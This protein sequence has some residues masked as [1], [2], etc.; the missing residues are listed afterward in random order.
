GFVA[1]SRRRAIRTAEPPPSVDS[2]PRGWEK[3]ADAFG[4]APSATRVDVHAT[5]PDVVLPEVELVP[6]APEF[7]RP[8]APESRL[9]RLRRRLAGRAGEKTSEI[10]ARTHI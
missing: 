3:P 8:E 9:V 5:P 10:P 7:E 1:V 6:E 4:D 2:A